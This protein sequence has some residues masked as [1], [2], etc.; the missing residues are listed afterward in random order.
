[1]KSISTNRL[2]TLIAITLILGFCTAA[3][4]DSEEM[5]EI[6]ESENKTVSDGLI[7]KSELLWRLLAVQ[8]GND[9]IIDID[10]IKQS[11][12]FQLFDRKEKQWQTD[13]ENITGEFEQIFPLIKSLN[14]ESGLDKE[15]LML[16]YLSL[17]EKCKSQDLLCYMIVSAIPVTTVLSQFTQLASNFDKYTPAVQLFITSYVVLLNR[18]E[19]YGK[20]EYILN[21]S[22]VE[23]AYPFNRFIHS[24]HHKLFWLAKALHAIQQNDKEKLSHYHNL[25]RI[26]GVGGHIRYLY[27]MQLCTWLSQYM[28]IESG[29]L[30]E[31]LDEEDGDDNK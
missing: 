18:Q 16:Q 9:A 31:E 13:Y 2:E 28:N 17:L 1:M 7:L 19:L 30:E 24:M 3:G 5:E 25:L 14:A 10:S 8:T 22:N 26:S 6:I 15:Q 4:L 29:E 12:D 20:Y 23:M 11:K 21:A 27:G